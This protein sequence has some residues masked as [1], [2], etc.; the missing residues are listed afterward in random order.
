MQILKEDYGLNKPT[1]F[2]SGLWGKNFKIF[3]GLSAPGPEIMLLR[4]N[5]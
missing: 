4:R 2:H 5:K 3:Y 1:I